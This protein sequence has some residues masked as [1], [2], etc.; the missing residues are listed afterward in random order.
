M[1]KIMR[2]LEQEARAA[3]EAAK[4]PPPPEGAEC[5]GVLNIANTGLAIE[6]DWVDEFAPLPKNWQDG[7]FPKPFRHQE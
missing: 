1:S 6:F 5:M 4:A 7:F 3:R 2:E